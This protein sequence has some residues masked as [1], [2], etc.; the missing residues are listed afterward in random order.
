MIYEVAG[1]GENL[2]CILV[3]KNWHTLLAIKEVAKRLRISKR[4]IRYAGIKDAKAVQDQQ[5]GAISHCQTRY[6]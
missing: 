4:R 3:K 1:S 6:V 5:E 2:I